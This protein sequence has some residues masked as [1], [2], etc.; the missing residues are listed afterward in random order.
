MEQISQYDMY[1]FMVV[2]LE[3][4]ATDIYRYKQQL[5]Y[6]N[7]IHF[8]CELIAYDIFEFSKQDIETMVEMSGLKEGDYFYIKVYN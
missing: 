4:L 3:T 7:K 6:V 5:G 8:D 1:K 2:D